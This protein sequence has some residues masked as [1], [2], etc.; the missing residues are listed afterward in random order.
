MDLWYKRLGHMSEKATQTLV[1]R[2]LLPKLK[3]HI[4]TSLFMPNPDDEDIYEK[5]GE[6]HEEMKNGAPDYK[7]E[8]ATIDE[9]QEPS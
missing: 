1:Q 8:G 9:P 2:Q 3:Y 5:N 6:M 4:L 7:S